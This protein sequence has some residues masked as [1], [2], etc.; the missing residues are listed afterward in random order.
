MINTDT[1]IIIYI[2]RASNNENTWLQRSDTVFK[3]LYWAGFR[4]KSAS[5]RWPSVVTT[6]LDWFNVSELYSYKAASALKTYLISLQDQTPRPRIHILAHSQG[7]AITSEALNEGAPF[8]TLILSQVA[9]SASCYDTNAPTNSDLVALDVSPYATPLS[10]PMGYLGVYTNITGHIANYFNT[11]DA[12]LKLWLTDQKLEKPSQF[13]SYDGTNGWY[14]Y[15]SDLGL[16]RLVT[17]AQES[18]AM[19]SRSRTWGIGAQGPN[20]GQT[21]QGI[22]NETVDL[23]AQFNVGGHQGRT[24]CVFYQDQFRQFGPCH[25]QSSR[26]MSN[27]NS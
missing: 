18:R 16:Y 17:D 26:I 20:P 23:N 15:D 13:Y 14:L 24:Q 7:G 22:I 11:N 25:D 19:I 3:R 6:D 1:N 5:V 2:H 21:N 8:D 9:M 12:L 10:R 4:G 27:T